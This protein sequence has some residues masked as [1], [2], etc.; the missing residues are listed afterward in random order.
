MVGKVFTTRCDAI[1]KLGADKNENEDKPKPIF[2][3]M[4]YQNPHAP[5]T[6]MDEDVAQNEDIENEVPLSY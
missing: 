5:I 1:S 4:S 6:P 3:V 2:M